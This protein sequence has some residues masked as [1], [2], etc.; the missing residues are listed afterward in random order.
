MHFL[1]AELLHLQCPV[2]NF[3]QP[4]WIRILQL[5]GELSAEVATQMC[6]K[7]NPSQMD[8]G[9]R[10]LKWLA[11]DAGL[12]ALAGT[13]DV[14]LDSCLGGRDVLKRSALMCKEL[15]P[16]L[17]CLHCV[18]REGHRITSCEGMED[19][20]TVAVPRIHFWPSTHG[21]L[22]FENAIQCQG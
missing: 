15:F 14:L 4:Q 20:K 9:A 2:Q 10:A 19:G 11:P 22:C 1:N 8:S 18:T 3:L 21:S 13:L 17:I 5:Q 6:L 7:S 16:G 12:V